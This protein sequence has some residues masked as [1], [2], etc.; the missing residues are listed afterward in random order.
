MRQKFQRLFAFVTVIVSLGCASAPG[1]GTIQF[2]AA[3]S[4]SSGGPGIVVN[5]DASPL[6]GVRREVFLQQAGSQ[7]IAT[8]VLEKLKLSGA[9]KQ[10]IPDALN[11]TVDH[12]RL[13]SGSTG[14]W[15]GWYAGADK[16]AVSVDV[17]RGGSVARSFTTNT[18]TVIA[19]FIRP[20]AV[21]R[22]DRMVNTLAQRIVDGI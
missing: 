5:I 12:F 1:G 6:S 11:I 8:K 18:S 19:G 9:A 16:L 3:P 15:R 17:V 22:F 21:E 7:K 4:V 13:R 14:F 2:T 10:R 20:G